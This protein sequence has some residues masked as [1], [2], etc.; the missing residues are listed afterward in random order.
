ME[1][2]NVC[3]KATWTRML[4]AKPKSP[5][6]IAIEALTPSASRISLFAVFRGGWCAVC[7]LFFMEW[8]AI[9]DLIATL[10][11]LDAKLFLISRDTQASA[12]EAARIRGLRPGTPNIL[13]VGDS[14]LAWT[15][16]LEK[17]LKIGLN[18][19]QDEAHSNQT[20]ICLGLQPA[21]ILVGKERVLYTWV[22]KEGFLA[23]KV[24]KIASLGQRLI[25]QCLLNP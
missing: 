23:E 14:E 11:G 22:Q 21:C 9:P 15:K 25:W 12:E 6:D 13:V 20:S 5:V 18:A 17:Q 10:Q 2:G 1:D 3:R 7:G 4:P 16:A 19:Y 24:R 8:I